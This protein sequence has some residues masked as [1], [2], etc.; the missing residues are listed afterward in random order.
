VIT[1]PSAGELIV[2]VGGVVSSVNLRE[3]G[4]KSPTPDELNARA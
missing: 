2:I 1:W 3:A 4:V